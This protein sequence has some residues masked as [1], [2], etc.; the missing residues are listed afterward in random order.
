MIINTIA[1]SS[2][3]DFKLLTK[4]ANLVSEKCIQ[5]SNVKQVYDC[6]YKTNK[7]L[8]SSTIYGINENLDYPYNYQVFVCHNSQKIF[9]SDRIL[10]I[11]GL[12]YQNKAIVYKYRKITAQQYCQWENIPIKQTHESVFAFIKAN[13]AQGNINLAKYALLST[14][15]QTLIQKHQQALTNSQIKYF[16]Q[17]IERV[18]FTPKIIKKHH[19]L[20]QIH[21]NNK[22]NILDLLN[23]LET[24]KKYIIINFKYLQ[25]NYQIKGLKRIEGQRD[26]QQNL[27]QPWLETVEID[28]GEYVSMG[29][30]EINHNTATI[31]MLIKR[32]V[33]LITR[34]KKEQISEVAGVLLNGLTQYNHYTLVSDGEININS[35]KIKISNKQTFQLLKDQ[36]VLTIDGN[37]PEYFNFASEYEL[38]FGD[39]PLISNPINYHNLDGI[40]DDLLKLQVLNSLISAQIKKESD[41]YSIEQLQEL[42]KH[43]ISKN[44]YL[45]FPTTNEYQDL[46]EALNNGTIDTRL[47]Y[48][49]DLGNTQILNLSKLYSANKFLNRLYEGYDQNNQPISDQLT[50]DLMLDN[51]IHFQHKALSNR[52]QITDIDKLMKNICDDFLGLDNN[53]IVSDILRSIKA[54]SLLNLLPIKWQQK[55]IDKQELIMALT[56]AKRLLN[57]Y[58]ENI[59]R[60]HISPLVFY[61]GTTGLLPDELNSQGFT[62]EEMINKYPELKISKSERKGTF[63]LVGNMVITVY[64]QTIYYSVNN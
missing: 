34:E 47:S 52:I 31:N 64:P 33:K 45:N 37:I 36:R 62:P 61:I 63:F 25:E 44:L 10:N 3:A 58:V 55:P 22:V 21:I 59:Y 39:L 20:S 6:L 13:L 27:I 7:L 12:Q 41:V 2:N 40:F 9:G 38:H 26:K 30:F 16:S 46:E 53:G 50:C 29:K 4:L 18:I 8:N 35:L 1:Y 43:Y 19:I 60:Q 57:S 54:D 56:Q 48:K 51:N 28:Q 5:A 32:Q 42:K 17:D 23:I 11:R 15:D 24:H 14:F 49:I